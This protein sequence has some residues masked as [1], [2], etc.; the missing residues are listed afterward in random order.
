MTVWGTLRD[1]VT[2]AVRAVVQ[3]QAPLSPRAAEPGPPGLGAFA[4]VRPAPFEAG[5]LALPPE[6]WDADP[7]TGAPLPSGPAVHAHFPPHGG[8]SMHLHGWFSQLAHRHAS[9]DHSAGALAINGIQSWLRQ[10]RP[11]HGV[12]WEH[13]SDA[14]IRLVNWHAG[15]AWLGDAASVELRAALAGSA[16][17]HL[18]HLATRLPWGSQFGHRRVAH[19]VG[20]FVGGLLF[21]DVAG[22]RQAWSESA[23]ALGRELPEL[24]FS[25]GSPQSGSLE[26][27][28]QSAWLGTLAAVVGRANGVPLPDEARGAI[29]RLSHFVYRIAG[30]SG[31]LPPVGATGATLPVDF[32]PFPLSWSVWNI[33]LALGLIE[34][35]ASPNAD[36]DPRRSW[37]FAGTATAAPASRPGWAMFSFAAD[38][39]VV[40]TTR[41]RNE[42]VRVL[43]HA[44][45]E[46]EGPFSNSTPLSVWLD[47]GGAPL[48]VG[49]ADNT[50]R[51]SGA[52]PKRT[53]LRVARVDGKRSRIESG[54]DLG[55]QQGWERDILLNQQR[56]IVTDRLARP[57]QISLRWSLG[58]DWVRDGELP[59]FNLKRGVHTVVVQLP[60]SLTWRFEGESV[61][62]T[63]ALDAGA[64]LVSSF[65]LR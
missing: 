48:L 57:G 22:A 10:D 44:R 15:L 7:T 11:G 2:G 38:G 53:F 17:W 47:V 36:I 32:F 26:F 59:N 65:E 37:F 14:A 56:M 1:R 62:G 9:G 8:R 13:A 40:A 60:A 52:V 16:S 54:A 55:A 23:A 28:L 61:V 4:F 49:D 20:R 21:R 42:P 30:E 35:E 41:V 58:S 5:G 50:L 18:D 27:A 45:A 33:N 46:S 39:W 24:C 43:T 34:G 3:G 31:T 6:R 25:D 12:G 64:E 19:H 63:G 51:V 29:S